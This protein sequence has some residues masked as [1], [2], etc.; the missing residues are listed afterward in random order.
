[1]F[2]EQPISPCLREGSLDFDIASNQ[3]YKKGVEFERKN[4]EIGET[5]TWNRVIGCNVELRCRETSY[6]IH[7]NGNRSNMLTGPKI[8]LLLEYKME[9]EQGCH[10]SSEN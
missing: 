2:Y 3:N 9:R 7:Q 8:I 6:S 10:A 4:K 1:V 5:L